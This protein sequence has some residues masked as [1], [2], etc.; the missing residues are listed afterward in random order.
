MGRYGM[1][2]FDR[3]MALV[4]STYDGACATERKQVD[5]A[6]AQG[7]YYTQQYKQPTMCTLHLIVKLTVATHFYTT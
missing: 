4:S 6:A 7:V 2:H 1:A 5:C 3:Q